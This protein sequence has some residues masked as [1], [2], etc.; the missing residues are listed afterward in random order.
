MITL[1]VYNILGEEV[2]ILVNERKDAGTYT[3]VFNGAQMPSGVCFYQLR[4]GSF[5]V[6]KTMMIIK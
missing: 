2:S 1:K 4:A 5:T 3:A 6:T